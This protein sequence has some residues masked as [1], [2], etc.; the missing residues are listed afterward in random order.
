MQT[1]RSGVV[2]ANG[3]VAHHDF[4]PSSQAPPHYGVDTLVGRPVASDLNGVEVLG[5]YGYVSLVESVY[6]PAG[7]IVVV[8]AVSRFRVYREP[9]PGAT[10]KMQL[11][12]IFA[13]NKT[14]VYGNRWGSSM[15]G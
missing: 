12:A 13:A 7:C 4:V 9:E 11:R 8:A 6:V 5:T 2:S 15:E 3:V 1:F 14:S 10:G